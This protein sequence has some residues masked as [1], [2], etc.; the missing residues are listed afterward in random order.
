MKRM[1]SCG[2]FGVEYSKRGS[3]LVRITTSQAG[4]K[5]MPTRFKNK[6]KPIHISIAGSW[7]LSNIL[8]LNG[9]VGGYQ[10]CGVI[11]SI[12]IISNGYG[13]STFPTDTDVGL[14]DYTVSSSDYCSEQAS[15]F[16]TSHVSSSL[17][18]LRTSLD[19]SVSKAYDLSILD[20]DTDCA[21]L[22]HR[23][24]RNE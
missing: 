22:Q 13:S 16:V 3:S 23:D 18:S 8:C 11:H 21:H 20:G 14:S 17:I 24:L 9:Q 6:I 2:I 4:T 5:G 7:C 10:Y 1:V 19:T 12:S 15:Q